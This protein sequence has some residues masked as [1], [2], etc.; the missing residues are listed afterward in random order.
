MTYSCCSRP[1]GCIW[2]PKFRGSQPQLHLWTEE[3]QTAP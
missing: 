2:M 3:A 1:S